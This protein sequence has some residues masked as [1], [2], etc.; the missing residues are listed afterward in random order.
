M[1][2]SGSKIKALRAKTN[3]YIKTPVRGEEPVFVV[4]GRREDVAAAK[5][6]ILSASEHFSQ[7]R[8]SRLSAG[9]A[10]PGGA[11]GGAGLGG[12]PGSGGQGDTAG[13]GGQ[14]TIH[15]RVPYRVVGLVVGPKGATIKRIQQ[16][17]STYIV[18]PSRDREPVF[19]VTGTCE[20]VEK[21]RRDIE[22]YIALRTGASPPDPGSAAAAHQPALTDPAPEHRD[23]DPRLL[24]SSLLKSAP[25]PGSAMLA[26]GGAG[27][28]SSTSTAAL[29]S[30]NN[31]VNLSRLHSALSP[32]S[33]ILGNAGVG[34]SG[35]G[36]AAR[37]L[38]LAEQYAG[39]GGNGFPCD[40]A[41]AF[42]GFFD[43]VDGG[44][45]RQDALLDKALCNN[46]NNDNVIASSALDSWSVGSGGGVHLTPPLSLR[47]LAS[48]LPLQDEFAAAMRYPGGGGL[49]AEMPP[50][51]DSLVAAS[52][53]AA[54]GVPAPTVVD[55]RP[56]GDGG[57]CGFVNG[58][59][60]SGRSGGS[61]SSPPA[62]GSPA[63]SLASPRRL[64]A[65]AVPGCLCFLCSECPVSAALVPCGHNLFCKACA[66]AVVTR[67]DP[68][69]RRCPVCGEQASLAIRILS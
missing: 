67:P 63:E 28:V 18:T 38:K 53:P 51:L 26:N 13:G 48:L 46:N 29:L 16:D 6:E 60:D 22:S 30:Y 2:V 39:C 35:F 8:A 44:A 54:P 23:V 19:E 56:H 47:S 40:N 55:V 21:A 12:R 4:T 59:S 58:G 68:A 31:A 50:S 36:G 10:S 9:I 34:G 3:T 32:N 49:V 62:S 45:L 11:G 57:L 14:V 15:V 69:E 33:D 52:Y 1:V 27:G 20:G 5:R 65:T 7:I 42:P 41:K 37:P 61:G 24:L 25:P 17:S 43:Y 66:D 64:Q